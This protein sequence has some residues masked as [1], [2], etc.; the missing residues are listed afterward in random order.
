MCEGHGCAGHPF[1]WW[2]GGRLSAG[3]DPDP[4]GVRQ[5][6]RKAGASQGPAWPRRCAPAAPASTRPSPHSQFHPG[7]DMSLGG[8]GRG[9]RHQGPVTVPVGWG[10]RG[11]DDLHC[12][13]TA[14]G[15]TCCDFESG[16][17]VPLLTGAA[18]E[19]GGKPA[20]QRGGH[21]PHGG[22][23]LQMWGTPPPPHTHTGTGLCVLTMVP[24]QHV[25]AMHRG[26]AGFN[27]VK[28]T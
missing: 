12:V 21:Q 4:R 23:G 15:G 28:T 27:S 25:H 5:R 24:W 3:L 1:W 8:R 19:G 14:D 17:V 18:S 13:S 9:S 20:G 6:V 10:F 16:T 26:R 7:P 22:G 2:W 11:G